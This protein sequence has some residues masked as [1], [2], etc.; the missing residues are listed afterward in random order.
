MKAIAQQRYGGPDVLEL[1]DLPDPKLGPDGVLV[2]VRAAGVNPVDYKLREGYLDGVATSVFPFVLGWDAAGVV[3]AV[4]PAV[5]EFA[6]G[7]EVMGYVRKDFFGEGC[8]A[9]LVAGQVRHWAAKPAT[10]DFAAAGA[11]PLAGLTALQALAAASV[12]A[13]DTVLI[14]AAAGGV[15]SFATQLATAKEARVIGTGSEGSFDRIRALGGEPVAY[16]DGLAERVRDLAPDGVD[17]ALDLVGG[18]ALEASASVVR[19]AGRIVSI[20]DAATVQR[21]GGRYVF[22]RP[23]APGLTELAR[24]VDEGLLSVDVQEFALG[25]AAA[26]H[27]LLQQGHVHGKLVLAP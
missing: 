25:E 6:P 24:L 18:E 5:T 17:A 11:L 26:A 16:G 9:E 15:G 22:V 1:T 21:L 13:G 7:E 3:E 12:S 19:E 14:N 2:R 8:Y 20:T 4:G 23:D 10:V 27:E